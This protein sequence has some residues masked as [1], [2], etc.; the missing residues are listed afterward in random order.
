M[1]KLIFFLILSLLA[2][3]PSAYAQ[4]TRKGNPN[5]ERREAGRR[6]GNTRQVSNRSTSTKAGKAKRQ[7][8]GVSG[9]KVMPRTTRQE[10]PAQTR[11]TQTP[12]VTPWPELPSRRREYP[13]DNRWSSRDENRT[14][15]DRRREDDCCRDR[16]DRRDWDRDD[17]HE[18]HCKGHGNGKGKGHYKKK[19]KGHWKHHGCD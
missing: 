6:P 7:S 11:R 10:Q 12:P 13:D 16:R 17:R 1:Q 2:I 3:N 15:R 9:R 19:G 14:C 8:V 4:T 18:Y 5:Q